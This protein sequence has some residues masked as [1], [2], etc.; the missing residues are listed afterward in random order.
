MNFGFL[1]T[2][3]ALFGLCCAPLLAGA[4]GT[5]CGD[6][7]G[8]LMLSISTDMKAPKD[9]SVVSLTILSNNQVKFNFLGRV[10]PN[11]DVKLP[12]TIAIAEAEDSASIRIRAIAFQERKPRVLRDV[13]TS[14]PHGGRIAL[15]RM[16]LNFI[17]DGSAGNGALTQ[18]QLDAVPATGALPPDPLADAGGDAGGTASGSGDTG[19][20]GSGELDPYSQFDSICGAGDELT[21]IDGVCV[22]ST[23]DPDSLPDFDQ[24]LVGDGQDTASCFDVRKCLAGATTVMGGETG[25]VADAGGGKTEPPDASTGGG[26]TSDA[27]GGA[28]AGQ[29]KADPAPL[30]GGF[31]AQRCLVDVQGRDLTK[32]NLALQTQGTGECLDDGRCFVPLDHGDHGWREAGSVIQLAPGICKKIAAGGVSLALAA[33]RS[34]RFFASFSSFFFCLASSR[35]RFSNE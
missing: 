29:F 20:F 5:A 21:Q 33:S 24:S 31:D 32:L 18:E 35:W 12:A 19:G 8:G 9:V 17:D 22:D 15:L 30:A 10:L 11:G 13:R 28:D 25:G 16:P 3:L 6:K 1:R 34:A 26:N 7:K 27:G 14:I 4:A 23:V 2:R